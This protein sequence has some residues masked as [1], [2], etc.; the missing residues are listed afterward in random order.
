MHLHP[1]GGEIF[2]G[3]IYRKNLYA[4][5]QA[6]QESIFRTFFAVWEDLELVLVVSESL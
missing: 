4:H 1:Q 5:P 3:V 6:E 2:L